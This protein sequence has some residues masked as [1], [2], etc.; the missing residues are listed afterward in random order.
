MQAYQ[1]AAAAGADTTNPI[2]LENRRQGTTDWAI[3][4]PGKSVAGDLAGQV[5]GFAS[6]N[7]VNRGGS[8]DLKVSVASPGPV[9]WSVYRLGWYQGLGGRFLQSGQFEGITQPACTTDGTTGMLTCPWAASATLDVPGDWLS[10]IYFVV[11]TR[12]DYQ[13]T[14]QF[15]VRDDAATDAV[16]AMV[17]VNTLQAYNNYPDGVG[18]SLYDFNS[19]G[20]RTAL[21]TMRATKVSFDR[22]YAQSGVSGK[23]FNSIYAARFLE[24]R[25]WPVA[26][27]TNDDLDRAPDFISRQRALV[28][29]G[30]DEYWTG[31]MYSAAEQSRDSGVDLGFL[32]GN[33]IFWQV[34][35]EA[36]TSGAD[37]RVVVCYKSTTLDPE[38]NP[39]AKTVLFREVGRPEQKIMGAQYLNGHGE[40]SQDFP[41]LVINADHWMY[42]GTGLVN[43][44]TIPR[45]VGGEVDVL[46]PAYPVPQ[47]TR[48]RLARSPIVDTTG[49]SQFQDAWLYTAP[50]GAVVFD[51]GTWRINPALGGV[52][53][54]DD[55]RV[56]TMVGNLLARFSSFSLST[57]IARDGG[58]DRYATAVLVSRHAFPNTSG[59][60]VLIATG[61]DFPDALA[62]APV[63]AGQ[64]P[65]LLV[66]QDSVPPVVLD[67]LIRLAPSKVIVA[68]SASVVSDGVVGQIASATGATVERLGGVDR[69]ETAA[70]LSANAFSPGTPI[71]YVAT[72]LD[73]PDALAA[74]AAGAHL[75]GPV[76]LTRPNELDAFTAAELRRLMP[77][78]IAVVGGPNVV[79]DT[80]M[81]QLRSFA[82]EVVRLAGPDRYET[83]RAVSRDMRGPGESALAAL[84]TGVD[85]PDALAAGPAVAALGGSLVLVGSTLPAGAAEDL[86]RSRPSTVLAVGG[87]GVVSANVLSAAASLFDVVNGLS[88]PTATPSNGPETKV[89]GEPLTGS[90]DK[91]E[92]SSTDLGITARP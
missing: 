28:S 16:V 9:T 90:P 40:T 14:V 1:A 70:K 72:G 86:V 74:A 6:A 56:R 4:Y 2:V 19:G 76:L 68:G 24:S 11:L 23:M 30:H 92:G 52:A 21:G 37:R 83:S 75:G 3:P 79:S 26:Y 58:A 10:G 7:S 34:R 42:R 85:F 22:P 41:W 13:N 82:P 64:G 29:T 48:W 5:K 38:T 53:P 61:T 43:G 67:E 55:Q 46:D 27:I 57:K 80:T 51:A 33:D 12:G 32:G 62:A 20:N 25:G 8:I 91:L 73:Y 87:T 71:A 59:G 78:R 63:T 31:A 36:S 69:Y 39:A 50:S 88:S 81:Q 84:A 15:I 35:Y 54:Y 44:S 45:L 49:Q 47:G 66:P 65:V 17:P 77:K 60:T 18:K 89:F